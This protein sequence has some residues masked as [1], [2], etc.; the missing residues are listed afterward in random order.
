[1]RFDVKS[2]S[3]HTYRIT[4]LI[5]RQLPVLGNIPKV[6]VKGKREK[7]VGDES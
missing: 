3:V 1:M 2:I 6:D 5:L 7:I 4:D